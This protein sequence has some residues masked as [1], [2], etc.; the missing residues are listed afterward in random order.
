[1]IDYLLIWKKA[2]DCIS[3]EEEQ[4]LQSWIAADPEHSE[5]F[6]RALSYYKNQKTYQPP[7]R[8]DAFEKLKAELTFKKSRPFG[9][10]QWAAAAVLLVLIS[11][12]VLYL[13]QGRFGAEDSLPEQDVLAQ[14]S[15]QTGN[16]VLYTSSGEQIAFDQ[17]SVFSIN[18]PYAE[19]AASGKNLEYNEGKSGTNKPKYNVLVIPRGESFKLQLADGTKVWLNSETIIKY[20]SA[21]AKDIREVEFTG[22]AY[23][24]V[25]KDAD[26]PFVLHSQSQT[27]RVLGTAFNVTSYQDEENIITTLVEG[28]VAVDLSSGESLVLS[29]NE[30]GR[31][32]KVSGSLTKKEVQV[33]NF[34]SWK[35]G[36]MYFENLE[37]QVLL[38]RIARWYDIEVLFENQGLK[39]RKFTGGITRYEDF[40]EF[41]EMLEAS[42]I[43][44]FDVDK[45]VVTVK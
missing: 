2:H 18:D 21:F 11:G 22:E 43:V 4:E 42:G 38:A 26:R 41:L 19:I 31:L 40:E 9:Q 10:W 23:F 15:S 39:T 14:I 32:N 17:D 28:S 8:E 34:I 7:L 30:Q 12:A 35:D 44:E 33:E 36:I 27:I 25:A 16:A 5:Y 45:N 13:S 1:M 24:E 3:A 20:P 37:L 29:P 6:Q